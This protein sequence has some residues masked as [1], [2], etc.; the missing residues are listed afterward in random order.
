MVYLIKNTDKSPKRRASAFALHC[1]AGITL[2]AAAVVGFFFLAMIC[3]T[4]LFQMMSLQVRVRN[5]LRAVGKEMAMEASANPFVSASTIEE[6]LAIQIGKE[7]LKDS[8]IDGGASGLDCKKSKQFGTTSIM[9]LQVTYR[10]EIPI[11]MFRIPLIQQNEKIR[12]KG[13]TGYEG[14]GISLSD[15]EI[16]YVTTQGIVYHKDRD[17]TYL[18]TALTASTLE[19]VVNLRNQ[20]GGKYQACRYCDV[21]ANRVVYVTAYGTRYHGSVNCSRIK[22]HVFE[23]PLKEIYGIGGCSK[24]VK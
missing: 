8:L 14:E 2:E 22:R 4:Y 6:K 7:R 3:L 13:W 1:K 5:G 19:D 21:G 10:I 16:V 23:V 11:L 9:D 20:S 12:I 24:C 15:S 17:C 18:E